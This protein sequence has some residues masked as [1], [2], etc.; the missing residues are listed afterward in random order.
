MNLL[1]DASLIR[2]GPTCCTVA[3]PSSTTKSREFDTKN[4][5]GPWGDSNY[6]IVFGFS[7][8]SVLPVLRILI[9][10]FF[11]NARQP[12]LKKKQLHVSD[13]ELKL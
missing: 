5:K 11:A 1:T 3:I 7:N 2:C 4:S 8:I 12:F 13:T 6:V 9:S 10:S